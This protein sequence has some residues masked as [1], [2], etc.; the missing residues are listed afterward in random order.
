M[1]LLFEN[2]YQIGNGK[3]IGVG[4]LRCAVKLMKPLINDCLNER[5]IHYSKKINAKTKPKIRTNDKLQ[6]KKLVNEKSKNKK[7]S[8][9]SKKSKSKSKNKTKL[10]EKQT[11]KKKKS[12]KK[13]DYLD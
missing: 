6:S 13:T 4:G 8:E 1:T 10:K 9:E 5:I 12:K 11:D 7:T 2:P 3:G